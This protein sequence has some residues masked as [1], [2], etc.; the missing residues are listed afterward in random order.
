MS[1]YGQP[2]KRI[3]AR[4]KVA[5]KPGRKCSLCEHKHNPFT[6]FKLSGLDICYPCFKQSHD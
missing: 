6:M 3:L 1:R 5:A 2:N 4:S